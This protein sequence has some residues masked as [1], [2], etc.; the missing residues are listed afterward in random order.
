MPPNF[1]PLLVLI[2]FAIIVLITAI[3]AGIILAIFT[4]DWW[5]LAL[6]AVALAIGMAAAV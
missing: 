5:W 4:G 3:P 1:D 2:Y 6:S